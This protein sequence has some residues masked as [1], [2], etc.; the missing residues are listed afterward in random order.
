MKKILFSLAILCFVAT[1][2][3]A[4]KKISGE[5]LIKYTITDVKTED[6]M[7]GMMKGSTMDIYVSDNKTRT[8]MNMMMGMMTMDIIKDGDDEAIML[9][10]MMAKKIKVVMSKEDLGK[11][12]DKQKGTMNEMTYTANKKDTKEIAGYK[13]HKVVGKSKDG[14]QMTFYI[15]EKIKL[16]PKGGGMAEAIQF[17]K[18]GGYPLEF[19]IDQGGVAMT[20]SAQSVT[21][22]LEKDAFEYNDEGYEEMSPEEL[23]KMGAGMGL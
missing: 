16:F 9:M 6:Q 19:S 7:A 2:M 4:Q 21:S 5:G 3:F 20:F 11:S 13:C 8:K 1:S 18:I 23:G 10:N 22:K 15:T 17:D 14:S 12:K